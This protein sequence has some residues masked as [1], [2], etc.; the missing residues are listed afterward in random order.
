MLSIFTVFGFLSCKKDNTG[1]INGTPGG[2]GVPVI[3]SVMTLTKTVTS[4][5]QNVGIT[6]N[7]WGIPIADT[8]YNVGPQIVAFDSVTT[9]GKLGNYYALRGSNLGSTTSILINGVSIYFNR[10][11]NSD[12]TVIFQ[13]PINIPFVQP[14]ANTITL[15]TLYGSVSYQF[16]IVP[17]PP[18]ILSVSDFDFI[19]NGKLTLNGKAF[20]SITSV[21]LKTTG[22]QVTIISKNDSVLVLKMPSSSLCTESPLQFTYASGTN[23]AAQSITSVIFN[24]LDNSYMIFANNNFQNMWQDI[25]WSGPSGLSNDVSHS[26]TASAKASYP[27][28]GYKVEGWA[29]Y[30]GFNYDPNYKFISF[31][32]KGGTVSHTFVLVGDQM[33]TKTGDGVPVGGDSHSNYGQ[34]N[35]GYTAQEIVVPPNV[36]TFFKIPL[37]TPSTP[38]SST[39]NSINY[40]ANGTTALKLGFYLHGSSGD[41][42]E[43]I[44]FDEVAFLK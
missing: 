36:W 10:S 19:A 34:I 22:D 3:N 26:G 6:Y 15:T 30:N 4:T 41:V 28:N 24:D 42:D 1:G 17:P 39:A 11:L 32:V 44:Y 31:W 40:W 33:A 16:T 7:V 2:K 35:D 18:T 20:S 27:A 21:A 23:N 38:W 12:Q 14:Q 25:S 9:T 29:N 37:S 13:V 8:T 5:T 43:T